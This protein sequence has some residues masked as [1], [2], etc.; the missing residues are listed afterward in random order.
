MR[1]DW[2]IN[3]RYAIH[4]ERVVSAISGG[5]AQGR[6]NLIMKLKPRDEFTSREN[7]YSLGVDELSGRHYASIPVT[8]RVVDYDEYY[9]LSDDDYVRFLA[10]P[11]SA[12]AFVE[13]CRRRE[14]DDLLMQKPGWNRGSPL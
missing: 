1:A 4:N 9:E 12:L 2:S 7:R 14:H 8:I 11:V 10:D 3:E 13:E 5:F 6:E